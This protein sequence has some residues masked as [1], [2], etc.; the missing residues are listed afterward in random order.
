MRSLSTPA[1]RCGFSLAYL[2]DAAST[3][4]DAQQVANLFINLRR[5][6]DGVRDLRA[7]Q[8]AVTATHSMDERFDRILWQSQITGGFR[9]AGS[10]FPRRVETSELAKQIRLSFRDILCLKAP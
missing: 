6:S 5:I 10:T 1:G 3:F 8:G 4:E 2:F 9:V 7:K